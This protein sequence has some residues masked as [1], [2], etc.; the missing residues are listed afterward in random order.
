M[1]LARGQASSEYER[2]YVKAHALC[3]RLGDTP[4]LFSVLTGLR[5]MYNARGEF[6][7]AR[8]YGEQALALA[9]RL[10]ASALLGTVHYSLGVA[11]MNLGEVTSAHAHSAQGI[12]HADAVRD[13]FW[14]AFCRILAARTLWC[15]GYPDQALEH[16]REA[17]ALVQSLHPFNQFYAL[18]E[19]GLI[20]EFRREAPVAHARSE[21]AL[22][23]ATEHGF[24][25]WLPSIMNQCGGTLAMLGHYDAGIAQMRPGIATQQAT[26]TKKG[27]PKLLARLAAAYG[28]SGQAEAGLGV[29]AE[30]LAVVDTTGDVLYQAE[31]HR[32]KGELLLRQGVPDAL[33]AE[34]CFYQ[35]IAI[36]QSQ[37]AKSWELRAA[38][39][40][41]KL[42]QSQGKRQQACDLLAP[43][44]GWFTEGFDTVD[45]QEAKALLEELA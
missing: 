10:Q 17:L 33:Q 13:S 3:Q 9:Q 36:S 30:A 35:A 12:T 29:L 8:Q 1:H 44:Y 6:Q 28:N 31:L 2:V 45:L 21:A 7:T 42:W 15:L 23:L 38:T 4:H 14:G 40:L 20:R 18:H 25:E 26:Q 5:Q 27:L 43:V 11:L 32:L 39:S 16:S 19:A 34:A 22:A 24:V 41:A 37:Q